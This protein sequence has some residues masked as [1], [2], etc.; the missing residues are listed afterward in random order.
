MG[1]RRKH[2]R[3]PVFAQV[4]VAKPYLISQGHARDISVGG[5][6]IETGDSLPEGSDVLIRILLPT[7]QHPLELPGKV[8][9]SQPNLWIGIAFYTLTENC[10][11]RILN[12]AQS[13]LQE[14]ASAGRWHRPTSPLTAAADAFIAASPRFCA[15]ATQKGRIAKSPLKLVSLAVTARC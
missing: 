8:V 14:E 6:R 2:I 12:Y 3:I 5:M 11:Q 7:E 15:G 10:R 1:D 9:S 13:A 4:E